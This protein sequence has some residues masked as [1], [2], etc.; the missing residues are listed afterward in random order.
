MLGRTHTRSFTVFIAATALLAALSNAAC[1]SDSVV[2]NNGAQ[3]SRANPSGS[4][5]AGSA[6]SQA[7]AAPAGEMTPSTTAMTPPASPGGGNNEGGRTIANIP[8]TV[9]KAKP[10]LTPEPDP[11]PPRPTPTVVIKNGKIVQQWQAPADAANL[12]NPVKSAPDAAKI[13]RALYMQRCA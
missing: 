13:G 7:G 8:M 5:A 10:P 11:F 12:V 6:N 1:K 2:S 3:N 9:T 4:P